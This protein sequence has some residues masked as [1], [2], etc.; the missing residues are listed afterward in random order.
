MDPN[1]Q[2]HTEMENDIMNRMELI[3]NHVSY[4]SEIRMAIQSDFDAID[5]L[6]YSTCTKPARKSL[7]DIRSL[8]F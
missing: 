4:T 3:D 6:L 5:R 1:L 7:V 2:S 8:K